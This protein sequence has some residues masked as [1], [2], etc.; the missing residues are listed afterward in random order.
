[1]TKTFFILQWKSIFNQWKTT[2]YL[3]GGKSVNPLLHKYLFWRI[4]NRQLLKTLWEKKKLLVTSNFS[5]SHNVFYSI[6]QLYPICPYFW[7]NIFICC[8][9]GRVQNWLWGK[10]LNVIDWVSLTKFNDKAEE[11]EQ[12]KIRPDEFHFVLK[13]PFFW[14]V[15]KKIY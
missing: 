15:K 1:M 5:F 11:K 8:W 14:S 4:N 9:I 7:H 3:F 6:R 13:C 12:S 10:G 2:I